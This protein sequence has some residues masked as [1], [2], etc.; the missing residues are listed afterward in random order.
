MIFCVILTGAIKLKLG[1]FYL[2]AKIDC[3][4]LFYI[5]KIA[6]NKPALEFTSQA[7]H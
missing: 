7:A 4:L 2:G 3:F 6:T 1:F 5:V